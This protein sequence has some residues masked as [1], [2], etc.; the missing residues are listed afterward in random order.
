MPASPVIRRVRSGDARGFTLL[1]LMIAMAILAVIMTLFTIMFTGTSKAWLNGEGHA[2]RRR[3]VRAIAD[4]IGTELQGALLP[5]A[6]S[7]GGAPANL[8]FIINPP[9]DR[10]SAD[11]RNADC[12]FWQAPLARETSFGEIAQVGYFVKWENAV[13]MLCRFFVNPSVKID[14]VLKPNPQF[15]IYQD[16]NPDLWVS[17]SVVDE[18]VKPADVDAGYK[19]LFAEYVLGLWI[20]S[21]GLDGVELPREYDSRVGYNCQFPTTG[22]GT[23]TEQRRLPATVQVSLAQ[24]DSRYAS[25][26]AVVADDM[27]ELSRET[28]TRDA[29]QFLNRLET[30]SANREDLKRL[31]PGIRIYTTQVQLQNAR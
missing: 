15:L 14:G 6:Q 8:Q 5:V 11:Y 24:I 10:L 4:F 20:R 16:A 21:F 25:R 27:R 13:P 9:V 29:A 7:T 26:L 12:I 3:N 22:G 1:E 28:N 30:A 2:E 17:S 19:G 18:V 31:L 23:V